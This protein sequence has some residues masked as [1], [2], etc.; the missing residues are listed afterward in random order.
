MNT[1][2][3][4]YTLRTTMCWRTFPM[5]LGPNYLVGAPV[6]GGVGRET[7]VVGFGSI[8]TEQGITM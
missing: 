7:D 8:R 6:D 5:Y 4:S 3:Y 2:K 1:Y